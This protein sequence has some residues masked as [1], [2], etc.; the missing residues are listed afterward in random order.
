MQSAFGRDNT[1]HQSTIMLYATNPIGTSES[2]K[3]SSLLSD[4]TEQ[5]FAF[6][7]EEFVQLFPMTS[8]DLSCHTQQSPVALFCTSLYRVVCTGCLRVR[9]W[10]PFPFSHNPPD[11]LGALRTLYSNF[12]PFVSF[13]LFASFYTYCSRPTFSHFSGFTCLLH[14]PYPFFFSPPRN[15][16]CFFWFSQT[17]TDIVVPF[18]E[19]KGAFYHIFGW[20]LIPQKCAGVFSVDLL[21]PVAIQPVLSR[22]SNTAKFWW[23]N[24]WKE[25]TRVWLLG[26]YESSL[27]FLAK[28]V[29]KLRRHGAIGFLF[30]RCEFVA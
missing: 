1:S 6:G 24:A 25:C 26:E 16:F 14:L 10:R 15:L 8:G 20:Q 23:R 17:R 18:S 12:F 21:L 30:T 22:S 19:K 5:P 27:T 7:N 4:D 29:R 11:P 13:R 28:H 3:W 2:G 9:W